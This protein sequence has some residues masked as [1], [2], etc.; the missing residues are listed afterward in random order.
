[1]WAQELRSSRERKRKLTE[2][3]CLRQCGQERMV[4][5][6]FQGESGQTRTRFVLQE[7]VG[8]LSRGLD[9]E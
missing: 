1:M 3:P 4:R 9:V 7:V 2:R 5:T 6:K 8:G